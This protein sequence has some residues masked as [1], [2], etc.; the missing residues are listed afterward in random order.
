M[1][2]C[3]DSIVMSAIPNVPIWPLSVEKY[4]Q[5]IAAGVLTE[6]DPVELLEGY[7]VPKMPKNAPHCNACDAIVEILNRLEL[8]GFF[9][10]GQNPI[11]TSDSEPEPD[12]AV[13]RGSRSK[14]SNHNPGPQDSAL[15]IEVSESSLAQDRGIKKRIYARARVPEYWILNLVEQQLEVYSQPF[16]ADERADYGTIQVL[17][18]SKKVPLVLDGKEYA[19]IPVKKLFG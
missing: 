1:P 14:F 4:H 12:I 8:R 7:L 19:T 10:R 3:G 9:V 2:E 15:I 5:M 17:T 6:D 16:Q 13:V 18:P 11:T